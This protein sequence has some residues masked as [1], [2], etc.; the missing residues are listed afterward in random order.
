MQENTP[1]KPGQ[2]KQGE[3]KQDKQPDKQG[4]H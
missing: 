4:K 1:Q 2:G 3:G